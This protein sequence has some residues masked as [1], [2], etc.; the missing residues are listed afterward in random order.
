MNNFPFS[1]L[2]L[3]RLSLAAKLNFNILKHSI[4]PPCCCSVGV[5]QEGVVT[6]QQLA[7][8]KSREG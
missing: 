6:G 8:K 3:F 4:G 1:F 5:G 2:R 7:S